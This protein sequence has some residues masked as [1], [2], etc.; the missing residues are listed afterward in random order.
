MGR[1]SN[2]TNSFVSTLT[3]VLGIK[4][5]LFPTTPHDD[6]TLCKD[7]TILQTMWSEVVEACLSTSSLNGKGIE[8]NQRL[9]EHPDHS[10]G[11]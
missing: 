8:Q 11:Y 9:H 7:R 5:L 1:G 3:I 4:Q 6:E 2:K 10:F